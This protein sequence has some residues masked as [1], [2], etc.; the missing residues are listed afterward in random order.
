MPRLPRTA[1]PVLTPTAHDEGCEAENHAR[2][3]VFVDA[4]A[5][6]KCGR[7]PALRM[8]L[9]TEDRH[10]AVAAEC[11]YQGLVLSER[12]DQVGHHLVERD[13]DHLG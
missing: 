3:V 13:H 2:L 12:G 11:T 5:K 8:L 6:V 9:P 1:S 10:E 7:D 4:P